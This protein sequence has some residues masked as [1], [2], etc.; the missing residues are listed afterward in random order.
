MNGK[1]LWNMDSNVGECNSREM[2]QILTMLGIFLLG[3]CDDE[4]NCGLHL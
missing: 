2:E 4:V 1:Q 3:L